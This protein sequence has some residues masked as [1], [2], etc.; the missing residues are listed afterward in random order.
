MCWWCRSRGTWQY[1]SDPAVTKL[2]REWEREKDVLLIREETS[3]SGAPLLKMMRVEFDVRGCFPG[4]P[5]PACAP[6]RTWRHT[7][8]AP[9]VAVAPVL[10][11]A[12]N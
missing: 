9:V 5:C 10:G 8:C 3:P 4:N 7:L 12:L 1:S 11:R 2:W 6:A